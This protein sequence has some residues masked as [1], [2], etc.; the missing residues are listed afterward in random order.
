MK[1][2]RKPRLPPRPPRGQCWCYDGRRLLGNI[3]QRGRKYIASDAIGKTIG[4]F[5][6]FPEAHHAVLHGRSIGP[7]TMNSASSD[8]VGIKSPTWRLDRVPASLGAR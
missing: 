8:A 7:Q 2:P 4:S 3:M 5:K 6:R 1:G